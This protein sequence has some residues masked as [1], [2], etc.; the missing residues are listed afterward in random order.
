MAEC[1]NIGCN[2]TGFDFKCCVCKGTKYCST[3]C[4]KADWKKELHKGDCALLKEGNELEVEKR[5]G[6]HDNDYDMT[7][8]FGGE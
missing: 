3:Q 8:R 6:L 1:G 7:S 2:N 5:R 4:Q